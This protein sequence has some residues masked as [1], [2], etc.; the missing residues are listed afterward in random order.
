MP[1]PSSTPVTPPAPTLTSRQ[2]GG[3]SITSNSKSASIPT[4]PSASDQPPPSPHAP[5]LNQKPAPTYR[6]ASKNQIANTYMG[7]LGGSALEKYQQNMN[8]LYK[9]MEAGAP[10]E[11]KDGQ[12]QPGTPEKVDTVDRSDGQNHPQ[13][14]VISSPN[15]PDIASDK[16][17]FKRN[18]PNFIRRRHSD[19]E[20]EE[21][22][23]KA[24]EERQE[25]ERQ[26]QDDQ[27]HRSPAEE[28]DSRTDSRTNSSVPNQ[29][30]NSPPSKSASTLSQISNKSNNK[31]RPERSF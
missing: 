21:S 22:V 24:L 18:T 11:E 8:R 5:H 9:N 12:V 15:Y 31:K 28:T 16:G 25:I 30:P 10:K 6:Y 29:P 14:G 27:N 26:R 2:S 4:S 1:H 23:N 13:F 3:N 7:R 20:N 19:S 17:S